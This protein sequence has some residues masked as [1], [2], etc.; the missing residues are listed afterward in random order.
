MMHELT[1]Q[2]YKATSKTL[3]GAEPWQTDAGLAWYAVA[4]DLAVELGRTMGGRDQARRG[5]ALLAVLSPQLSW[6]R[7]V[8]AA[9]AAA[10]RRP[11]VGPF[12][13]NAVKAGAI[14]A[15]ASY[16]HVADLVSGQKVEAFADN[17]WRPMSSTMVTIDRVM[18]RLFGLDNV[19]I[20]ERNDVYGLLSLG[21]M[22]A[23]AERKWLPHQ[24]QAVA[25]VVERGGAE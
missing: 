24:A 25:W 2:A 21:V 11:I 3:D 1:E 15:A 14:V 22:F 18:M 8:E 5:A 16:P 23:A 12:Q 9:S 10:D 7:T 4:H 13:S 19:R 17:I 6:A 20:L